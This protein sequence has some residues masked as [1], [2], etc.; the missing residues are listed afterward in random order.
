M[1]NMDLVNKWMRLL[2]LK[3][4]VK[5]EFVSIRFV[6]PT[7]FVYGSEE[8][9][10]PET[11]M[12]EIMNFTFH[13]RKDDCAD[14]CRKL[15]ECY[16]CVAWVDTIYLWCASAVGPPQLTGDGGCCVAAQALSSQPPAPFLPFVLPLLLTPTSPYSTVG[17]KQVGTEVKPETGKVRGGNESARGAS[18][19]Q[20]RPRK[21][22]FRSK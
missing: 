18:R 8:E 12:A 1:P 6:N 10:E 5:F 11:C 14:V 2:T 19:K 17:S 7:S 4:K 20:D 15:K 21:D 22:I 16:W 3:K 9:N 13:V